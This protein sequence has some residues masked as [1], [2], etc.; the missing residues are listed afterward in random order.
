MKVA[1]LKTPGRI[2]APQTLGEST[3]NVLAELGYTQGEIE[4]MRIRNVATWKEA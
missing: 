3:R 1:L 4:D 2:G